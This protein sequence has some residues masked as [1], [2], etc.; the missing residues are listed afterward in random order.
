MKFRYTILYVENVAKTMSF[1]EAAFGL[2]RG[3]LHE[4][5]DFGEMQ[6]G[7][8]KLSFASKALIEQTGQGVGM[9]DPSKA[10]FEIAFET[11]D[12]AGKFDHAVKSGAK[13]VKEP[14]EMPWGQTVSYVSDP[15]GNLVE[16]CSPVANAG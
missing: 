15:D 10:I 12:V 1:Y 7:E 3:F 8:T 9:A 2:T 16:I 14:S 6:T 5:G 11:D 4:A 13:S